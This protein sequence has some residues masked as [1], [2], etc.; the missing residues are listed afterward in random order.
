MAIDAVEVE[1]RR[2]GRGKHQRV[3]RIDR[4]PRPGVGAARQRAAQHP[5]R[6]RAPNS[7]GRGIVWNV[8]RKR[9]GLHVEGADVAGRS[10]QRLGHAAPEDDHVLED[11]AG[12]A[13]TYR[14]PFG[15]LVQAFAQVDAAAGPEAAQS[16]CRL[17]IDRPEKVAM[18]HEHTIV[19]HRDAAVAETALCSAPAG[20]VELP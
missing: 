8:Q 14:D 15:R 10:R 4:D 2:A 3:L 6:C 19:V 13:R 1:R 11:R 12:R 9:A 18:S 16:L 7:P 20:R 5:A 17:A